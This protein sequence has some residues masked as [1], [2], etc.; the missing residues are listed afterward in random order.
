MG[1]SIR[2]PPIGIRSSRESAIRHLQN[3]LLVASILLGLELVA[4]SA[5][6]AARA[7][8]DDQIFY[9]FMPIAWRDSDADAYRDGDF[10]GMQ[11]SL[12]YL[13]Q[14][15]ITAIWMNPIF[16]SPAYHGYQHGPADQLEPRLGTEAEWVA[17][18]RAAHARGIEVY[19]D[20]VAYGISQDTVWFQDAFG[21]PASPYDSWLAFNDAA[22]TDYLGSIYTTWNGD[23]VGFVHWD[24]RTPE[25]VALVTGW[26]QKWLDPNG[27]GV[28]DDGIDGYRLDHVWEFYPFGP[29]GWGYG[30]DSFWAPWR[31]ALR[32]VRPEVL[33]FSEQADWGS[34][35]TALWRGTDATFTKPFE[36]A[37]RD[38]LANESAAAL[39]ASVATA[40]A[41]RASAPVAG[42]FLATI[43]D[44]DVDR[45]ATRI[46][47]GFDKGKAA[48]AVLLTQP[49]PPVIYYGDEIGMRGAKDNGLGG[50]ASDIPMREPMKWNALE[51][52]PMSAYHQRNFA[53]WNNRIARDGDGRSVEEQEGVAGSLLEEYRTLIGL[54]RANVALRRGSYHPIPASQ[55]AI[56]SF[57]REDPAQ[58]LVVAINLSGSATIVDLDLRSFDLGTSGSTVPVSLRNSASL[59]VIDATNQ[60]AYPLPLPAY[61]WEIL[62][63]QMHPRPPAPDAIDGLGLY[64]ALMATQTQ[65]AGSENDVAELDVLLV[66]EEGDALVLGVGGNLSTADLGL[67]LF[68]DAAPGGQSVLDTSNLQPP[69]YGPQNLSG[70]RFDAGFEPEGFLYAND[71][72]GT[73]YVDHFFLASEGGAS[74]DYRGAVAVDSGSGT[75]VG[76]N[77]P[78]GLEVALDNSNRGG[79]GATSAAGAEAVRSGFEWRIPFAELGYDPSNGPLRLALALVWNDGFWSDQFLP[80]SSSSGLGYAPDFRTVGGDQFVTLSPGTATG[81]EVPSPPPAL[82]LRVRERSG[83]G[84]SLAGEFTGPARTSL[85]IFDLR[86]RRVRT[87]AAGEVVDGPRQWIFDGRGDDGKRLARGVYFARL[88]RDGR[89]AVARLLWRR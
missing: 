15:G 55:E 87:L 38:A 34:W 21:N 84:F 52:P 64:G 62:Q 65:S 51:G 48:A 82:A 11:A 36:F 71:A 16:P 39:Y 17:F 78:S 19:V 50:D 53:A 28:F 1:P 44:H 3:T 86:G 6:H 4:S 81:V 12:A 60:A 25:P 14:L 73:L 13:E 41:L 2:P 67:A 5:V 22:N 27:D 42:D 46:G 80:R 33:V 72:Q 88:R 37:A 70:T 32:Q 20:L 10:G 29:D 75:L 30:I 24:L 57:L 69:P 45:L 26:A 8:L 23:T 76:G 40:V 49:F 66:R 68:Y 89:T 43:G 7:D 85:A 9:Q 79:V 77:N 58:Q 74:K 83:G 31:Q 61:G 56:W 47:D 63:V 54:R 18:V 35:G 59:P